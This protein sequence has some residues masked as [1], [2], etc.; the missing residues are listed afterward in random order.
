MP[1][2]LF[3]LCS[4][5]TRLIEDDKQNAPTEKISRHIFPAPPTC[6]QTRTQVWTREIAFKDLHY[7]QFFE[8][9]V[10]RDQRPPVPPNMPEDYRC[11]YVCVCVFRVVAEGFWGEVRKACCVD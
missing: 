8:T 6:I 1:K 3:P 10:L 7:G 2:A 9:V 4:R 5:N 11:G